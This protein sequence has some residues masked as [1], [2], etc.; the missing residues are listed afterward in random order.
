MKAETSGNPG[1]SQK[2]SAALRHDNRRPKADNL[3]GKINNLVTTD[4]AN[5]IDA[6]DFLFLSKPR[7]SC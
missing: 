3:V 5:V 1:D 2:A 7:F 4:M 6:R